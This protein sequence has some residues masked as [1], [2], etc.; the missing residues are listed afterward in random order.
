MTSLGSYRWLK[1]ISWSCQLYT[2]KLL[3]ADESLKLLSLHAFRSEVPMKGFEELAQQAVQYCDGNPLALEVLGSS[4]HE[5]NTIQ[6]WE[7]H[8]RLLEND[9]NN[10]IQHVLMRSYESLPYNSEKELFLHIACFFVG[11]DKDYVVKILEH[12]YSAISGIKALTN[13]CLLSI[14]PSKKINMHRLLQEMG[15]NIVRQESYKDAAKRSRVI[16]SDSFAI[17]SKGKVRCFLCVCLSL[18]SYSHLSISSL[19]FPPLLY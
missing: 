16:G 2:V 3:D 18:S 19:Y 1:A 10:K 6:Y 7:S 14:S 9:M 5:D 4:L 13:R 11:I 12:D 8:L 15:K 17:L